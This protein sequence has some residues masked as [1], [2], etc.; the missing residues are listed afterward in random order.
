M[1]LLV[2]SAAFPPVCAGEADH[3]MHL[4]ERL[5]QRGLNVHVLTT[6]RERETKGHPFSVHAIM[7]D[8]GWSDLP[9]FI[10][11]LR[12]CSPNAV[13]L[14]YTPRDYNYKDM[15]TFAPTIT[16]AVSPRTRFVTQFETH[17]MAAQGSLPARAIRKAIASCVS[18]KNLDYVF[19]TLLSRSDR[20]IVLSERHLAA[21][22]NQL[23]HH[24][25]GKGIV[26]PPSPL[27]R[28]CPEE[29]GAA[30]QRGRHRLGLKAG[31]FLIA[32]YGYIYGE[33]GIE[34][35]LEALQILSHKRSNTRLVM[36]GGG[37]DHNSS[38]LETLKTLAN[39]LGVVDKIIWTGEYSPDSDEASLFLRAADACVFPFNYG[40]TLNRSSV[41]AAA[42]HGLPIV[43]TRGD[44]LE[45]AFINGHNVL[46]CPPR[47]ATSIA[48]AVESLLSNPELR[49]R[50]ATGALELARRYFS[51]ETAL[52]RTVRALQA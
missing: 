26:I 15:I 33:K 4:C 37:T 10:R 24:L 48:A 35:L 11:F 30:R 23:P 28:I 19:G 18:S 13:L 34:T 3:A 32:Y 2:I 12:H 14:I 29:N 1:K 25:N 46:L 22:S 52:Q 31:D 27:L 39:S 9:R 6:K 50:L 36:I 42:V 16:K 45:S 8:W 17:L 40:V 7:S 44:T 49:Q 51:W 5:A 20:V 21:L 43:T 47:D 41:A 38:Y